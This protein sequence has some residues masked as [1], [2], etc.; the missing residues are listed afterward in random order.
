MINVLT[1]AH[2]PSIASTHFSFH[3]DFAA[4]YLTGNCNMGVIVVSNVAE[5]HRLTMLKVS[6]ISCHI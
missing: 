4:T 6:E 2:D 1:V 3:Y 5:K